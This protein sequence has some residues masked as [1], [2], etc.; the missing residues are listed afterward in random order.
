[1]PWHARWRVVEQKQITHFIKKNNID[2]IVDVLTDKGMT[3]FTT[4]IWQL[5][6][7][8]CKQGQLEKYIFSRPTNISFQSIWTV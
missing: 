2:K 1:M 8:Y 4:A 7:M 5:P 3:Y 6:F